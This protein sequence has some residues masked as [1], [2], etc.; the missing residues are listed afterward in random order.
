MDPDVDESVQFFG[1]KFSLLGVL[2]SLLPTHSF[3]V[4][5]AEAVVVFDSFGHNGFPIVV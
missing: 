1:D 2:L 3:A 5:S 4:L